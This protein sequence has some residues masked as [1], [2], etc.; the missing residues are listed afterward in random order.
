[1]I[2]SKWPLGKNHRLAIFALAFCLCALSTQNVTA[3]EKDRFPTKT[4]TVIVPQAPGGSIDLAPR[5]FGAFLG[6]NLGR[7]VVI[8]NIPGAAGK[9]GLTKVWKAKPD[10]YTLVYHGIP[11][12]IMNEYISKTE[13]KT[14]DFR[15]IFALSI[16]NMVLLVHP[17]DWRTM[18]EFLTVAREKTLSGGL[19]SVG[20]SAHICGLISAE[21]LGMKVNWVP[22]EGGMEAL[23]QLAGKHLDFAIT[24]TETALTMV[25]AGKV[26]PLLVYSQ[27]PD[28]LLPDVPFPSKLGY[29]MPMM[30]SI[31]GF[32]APPNTPIDRVKTLEDAMLKTARDPVYVDWTKKRKLITTPLEGDKYLAE[33]LKQY[34]LLEKYKGFFKSQ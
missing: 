22:F 26:R 33:T 18:D 3:A 6:K 9:I 10:G 25:I 15:H 24:S 1:M 7:N 14:S 4:I 20:S 34:A 8:E 29:N 28:Q 31:R 5:G 11:Q 23:S 19:A 2:N 13:Y 21:N 16:N 12:S 32:V 30:S 17:D 27:E